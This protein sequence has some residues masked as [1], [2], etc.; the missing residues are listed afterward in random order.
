MRGVERFLVDLIGASQ[1]LDA[2]A[3]ESKQMIEIV[4]RCP[5]GPGQV[6]T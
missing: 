3:D 2:A 6:P 4:S 1:D 5:R